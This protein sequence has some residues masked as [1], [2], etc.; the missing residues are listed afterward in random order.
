MN[1]AETKQA[2]ADQ[3]TLSMHVDCTIC[4]HAEEVERDA[5]D[6][7]TA[8]EAMKDMLNEVYKLGWRYGS[9]KHYGAEGLMCPDCY[10]NRNKPAEE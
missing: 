6:F 5:I 1:A 7:D 3:A 9:S 2:I 4:Y 8:N 10:K